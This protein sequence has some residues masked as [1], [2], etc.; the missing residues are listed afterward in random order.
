M[1]ATTLLPFLYQTP[2]LQRLGKLGASAPTLRAFVHSS[3]VTPSG[4]KKRAR[5]DGDVIPFEL[6]PGVERPTRTKRRSKAAT[7]KAD[8]NSTIT[9]SEK[10]AFKSIFEEIAARTAQ[11]VTKERTP[12]E[13]AQDTM[14]TLVQ[15]ANASQPLSR[16]QIIQPFDPLNPIG[17]LAG[18]KEP[19]KA[20]DRFPPALRNAAR[21]AL[22]V[23]ET[24]RKLEAAQ[25][26]K[27]KPTEKADA[28]SK[29]LPLDV[30]N[31]MTSPLARVVEQESK[32][33]EERH[34]VEAKMRAAK[35]DFE[36]WDVLE[37]EVFSI[38]GRLTVKE[39]ADGD[40]L[41]MSRYGPLYPTYALMALRMLDRNFQRSSPLTLNVLPRV[42]ELGPMSYVLAASTPFYN[43][44]IE[45][46]WH[47]Y[48]NFEAV[49]RLLEEMRHSGL[50]FDETT[51]K[52]IKDM[53]TTFEQG[54]RNKFGP[55]VRDI[56]CMPENEVTIR[57]RLADWESAV[58]I[59]IRERKQDFGLMDHTAD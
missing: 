26:R 36:L 9:P 6:P 19:T 45:I 29:P 49:F 39:D 59:H 15:D 21:V 42:K 17:Q 10:K 28:E 56:L 11:P 53:R 50:Y 37:E 34:R 16:R 4:R 46:Q 35:T 32:R 13:K 22:G 20:L 30:A 47:R 44:L 24:E 51:E 14:A 8:P 31:H 43:T 40:S 18:A 52:I 12:Q 41:S 38:V 23:F 1:S 2:T 58:G 57:P 5:H 7:S 3:S 25:E 54:T 48:N 55:F 33:R 27:A